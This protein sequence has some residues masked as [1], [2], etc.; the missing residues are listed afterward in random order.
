[1]LQHTSFVGHAGHTHTEPASPTMPELLP[2]PP[3]ELLEPPLEDEEPPL[4]E[5]EPPL[6]D[7]VI[8]LDEPLPDPPPLELELLVTAHS[9]VQ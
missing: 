2:E 6:E 1:M 7:P 4:E 8:P 5:E 9:L 3:E